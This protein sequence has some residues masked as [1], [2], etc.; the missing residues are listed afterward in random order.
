MLSLHRYVFFVVGWCVYT[1]LLITRSIFVHWLQDNSTTPTITFLDTTEPVAQTY[2]TRK[3]ACFELFTTNVL[4]CFF[5]SPDR[6]RTKYV[7]NSIDCWLVSCSLGWLAQCLFSI[8]Y[9]LHLNFYSNMRHSNTHYF[10]CNKTGTMILFLFIMF[11]SRCSHR[12]TEIPIFRHS[13]WFWIV[14]FLLFPLFVNEAYNLFHLMLLF[15]MNASVVVIHYFFVVFSARNLSYF[16]HSGR[17]KNS[18]PAKI[19]AM[20]VVMKTINAYICCECISFY[21]MKV[22]WSQ[23]LILKSNLFLDSFNVL[24]LLCLV[25]TPFFGCVC[26]CVC[27][28]CCCKKP[29]GMGAHINLWHYTHTV[30]LKQIQRTNNPIRH[31]LNKLH[32]T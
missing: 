23:E 8:E 7:Y 20:H 22:S 14:F 29:I 5:F 31:S 15:E 17:K 11:D 6:Q 9:G 25:I 21:Y 32:Y 16:S 27:C 30:S 10:L 3:R 13:M 12:H 4:W 18:A 28:H 2:K 19:T 24:S 26:V 1:F